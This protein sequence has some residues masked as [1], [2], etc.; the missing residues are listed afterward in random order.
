MRTIKLILVVIL[1]CVLLHASA[2]AAEPKV[3]N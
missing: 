3:L 1:S 2:Q